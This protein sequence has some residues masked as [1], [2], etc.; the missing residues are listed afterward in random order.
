[1]LL[2]HFLKRKVAV[3]NP[4][5]IYLTAKNLN[6]KVNKSRGKENDIGS[7]EIPLIYEA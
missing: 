5:W 1:M 3:W 2:F 6:D 4:I 7:L